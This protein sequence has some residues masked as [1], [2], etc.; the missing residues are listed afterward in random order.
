MGREGRT[1]PRHTTTVCARER[2]IQRIARVFSAKE[3][4]RER[5]KKKE[6]ERD[7]EDSESFLLEAAAFDVRRIRGAG[8]GFIQSKRSKRGGRRRG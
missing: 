5:Y 2:E 8:G 7:T 3:R 4:E 1:S 6:R